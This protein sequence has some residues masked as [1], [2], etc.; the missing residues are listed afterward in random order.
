MPLRLT[1]PEKPPHRLD[2]PIAN[3]LAHV[4]ACVAARRSASQ[5]VK[6]PFESA[7]QRYA[8]M[9]RLL[10]SEHEFCRRQEMPATLE[11]RLRRSHR[12][13]YYEY[14]RAL[15]KE[16]RAARR[17]TTV[18]MASAEQWSGP[19]VIRSFAVS[20]SALLRLRWLGLKSSLGIEVEC[21]AVS[22]SLDGLLSDPILHQA[23]I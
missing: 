2:A 13:S 22:R 3:A 1:G 10:L 20:E 6:V 12:K 11:S 19:A 17:Q 9:E 15:G 5:P 14:L 18:A 7:R 4:L 16:V 21:G 23:T 8:P